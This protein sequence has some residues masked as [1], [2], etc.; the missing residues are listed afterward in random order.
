METLK[1][2]NSKTGEEFIGDT[3]GHISVSYNE[4]TNET[5][6]PATDNKKIWLPNIDLRDFSEESLKENI[7]YVGHDWHSYGSYDACICILDG[8]NEPKDLKSIENCKVLNDYIFENGTMDHKGLIAISAPKE[9]KPFLYCRRFNGREDEVEITFLPNEDE[10]FVHKV[11]NC[12][13]EIKELK[14]KYEHF[15]MEMDEYEFLVS[16]LDCC[17]I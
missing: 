15:N 6:S 2:I 10:M 1:W 9:L 5:S 14:T 8:N 13:S 12:F 17:L 16:N 7:V 3:L 4:H 11:S